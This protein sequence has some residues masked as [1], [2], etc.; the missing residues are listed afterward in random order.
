MTAGALR[1]NL[2]AAITTPAG[3]S[4]AIYS[5]KL[6]GSIDE[7]RY[8]KTRRTSKDIGRFWFTQ[9][10]GGT[11]TDPAPNTDTQEDVNTNLGVYFKFNEGITGVTATDQ[12]VLDYSGRVSNGKWTGYSTSSRSTGSAMVLSLA[13]TKEFKDPIIYSGHPDVSSLKTGLQGSGSA[14]DVNNVASLYNTIPSWITEEDAEGA[15]QAKYLTQI[16]S[17]YFDT[18]HMQ[19]GSLNEL[20][21]IDYVSGSNKPLPF[22]DRKLNAQGF[23]SPNIFIDADLL[24]KLA[25]RSEERVYDKSLNDIKNIIYQNI[26]NNL[27]HIYKSKGTEKAFRNL[28]RCFGIDEELVKL[29]MYADNTVYEFRDNRKNTLIK[30]SFANFNTNQNQNAVVYSFS[31]SL[32]SNSTGFLPAA[33]QLTG[34]YALTFE[35]DAQ[36]PQKTL[37]SNKVYISTNAIS[38]SVFGVHGANPNETQVTWPSDDAVNFQVLTIR[39]ER[40]SENAYFMLTGSAGGYVP[41]LTSSLYEDLYTDSTWNLAVRI[42]PENYPLTNFADGADS[43]NYTV[44]FSGIETRSG[45]VVNTFTVSGAV[46]SP[47]NTFITGSRRV[48]VG[49]HRTNITGALLQTSDVRINATRVWLNYLEDAAL[50]QHA[51]DS[52]NHGSF[53]PSKYAFAFDKGAEA[54]GEVLNFDTLA[55]NWEFTQN[56]GSDAS[57]EFV[58]EDESSGSAALASSR[59]DWAGDILNKQVMAKGQGFSVSST[60]AIKKD[61][62][63]AARLNDLETIAPAETIQVLSAEDQKVFKI[64]SRPINYYFSFEKSMSEVISQEI[65]N[66]FG[67]LKDFNNLV[68]DPVNRYRGEYKDL[69]V[70]RQ[71]YFENVAN[72][73]IDFDKFYEFYKWFDS[74]LSFML[75][76]LVPASAQFSEN[77]QT[78]IESHALE[79]S[80]YRNVFQFVDQEGTV[81]SGTLE[82]NVDYGEAISSPDDDPQ[83][84]GFYPAHAPTRRATGLS[85][86]EMLNKWKYVHAPVDADQKKKYL[87]WKNEA[88][89][90]NPTISENTAVNNSRGSILKSIR[91]ISRREL[92][93]PYRFSMAG[94]SELNG[95]G[96][97][98]NKKVNFV[99]EATQPYGPTKTGTNIPINIMLTF[100]TDVESLLDTTDEFY[101]AYRQRL[102]FGINPDINR[103]NNDKG[104]M[105][106]NIIA[107]FSLYET[108]EQTT[109][110]SEIS[111][112]FKPGVTITN[113]HHDFVL[114]TAI[115]AQGPFTQKFV[116]G[117]RYRHTEINDGSDTRSSRAEG[118]RLA[119]GLDSTSEFIPTGAVGALGIVSPN[120]P[121]PDS[122]AGSAPDG[123]LPDVPVAQ[124]FRDEVAKRPVNIKNIL[125]TTASVGTR[126]SGALVHN[127]IGNYQKNYQVVQTS[128][129]S[130]N[131]PFFQDQSFTFA[132]NPETLATRGRFPLAVTSTE[133]VGGD[134]DYALPDRTGNNSNNT[135][136]VSLFSSPGSYEASSR[137]Y[138]DPAHEEKSAYNALPYRNLG[139]IN[140]G[141]SGS[142]TD[143]SLSTTIRV[144]DHLDKPR[145]L[146]QIATLHAGRFGHDPVFGSIP[147]LTY[148]TQ[149]SFHKTNRNT[150]TVVVEGGTN[151]SVFDNLF[152]QHGIPRSQQQYSWVTASLEQ[153]RIIYD[154]DAPTCYSASVINELIISGSDY[155]DLTFVGLNTRI[156]DPLT[157]SSHILGFALAADASSAYLNDLYWSSALSKTADYFN[158]ITTT[159]NGPYGYPTWKQIRTGETPVA[160]K[161]R[162]TNRISLA[163]PPPEVSVSLTNGT[164]YQTVRGLKSNG[165]VDYTEQ[166]VSSRFKSTMIMLED[167]SDTPNTDN[168]ATI[169]ISHGNNI[170]FFSNQG[171]NNR[172]NVTQPSFETTPLNTAL[173]YVVGSKLSTVIDYGERIYP[174]ETNVYKNTVRKRTAYTIDNIWNDSR[175]ERTDAFVSVSDSQTAI[176]SYG[177]EIYEQS[178]WPLDGH[179]NFTTTLPTGFRMATADGPAVTSGSGELLNVYTRFYSDPSAPFNGSRTQTRAGPV[180]A[181]RVPAGSASVSLLGV[182]DTLVFAGDA[183][184]LAGQQSGKKPYKNYSSYSERIAL[185]GKDHSIVPE[186]RISDLIE[187]YID[188]KSE[189]FLADV[190]NIF[191]L[192]GAALYDSSE[193]DFFKTYTNS[194]FIKYFS[195][196]D[197]SLH[198]KR[199][200]DLKIK[201]DKLSLSCNALIKFLP[202]K[203]FYPAERTLEIATLLSTSYGDHIEVDIAGAATSD[204]NASFRAFR[205]TSCVAWDLI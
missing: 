23:V 109:V 185:I 98:H 73:E 137:G 6:S 18:L 202:Y 156:T 100:D 87:W 135:V 33:T 181:S 102:G 45:E 42:K 31:S 161:L 178:I 177:Q 92:A 48:F 151:K 44:V 159:R 77:V 190:D 131:D 194:D 22:S 189:D 4:A 182:P 133:N 108:S 197:D 155:E 72:D 130:V 52:R 70:M 103:A 136:F 188:T 119:L 203:G 123:F 160:R 40:D 69:R 62:I 85:T 96:A 126:L 54:T 51:L 39:D 20:K 50:R 9:V 76:Q 143:A 142:N 139:V 138:R 8:W 99:F 118:F 180:Y 27:S 67:T 154:L 176:T 140:R 200:G 113:L 97:T 110:N 83:G 58:V 171:L 146:N 80:K 204:R 86:R 163:L 91:Q 55:L 164:T 84:T 34:G 75:G 5:G 157:A 82:S 112:S 78:I 7:F 64:D 14:Y 43:G 79:R 12:K 186:F 37:P 201:R 10:G 144:N 179:R 125:M 168:N 105:N 3:T 68:G 35:V 89:R 111:S 205:G 169:N 104:K 148:V 95:V 90:N 32:N 60:D 88:E 74:S 162:E 66:W 106:G 46:S 195:V 192:T 173:D 198:D 28:I 57:G 170:D 121:F 193:S 25:D 124:R 1:A 71:R 117:R 49:A 41:Q 132:P 15:K 175:S 36:F 167:N 63:I 116:G 129:R 199:A 11:N 153:G 120:Y 114:D 93:R 2:G 94:L 127:Q 30:D 13:A 17:S 19:I 56:T 81:F 184:W 101:P 61:Y 149:P 187:T 174:S 115:P 122:P 59:F 166:P 141:L 183:E 47:P 147:S 29:K 191:N 128:G 145:G 65:L 26:Y 107:P 16:L 196:V 158:F 134:L 24:E 38:S 150:K 53:R 152:V 21:N 165:F 172:L